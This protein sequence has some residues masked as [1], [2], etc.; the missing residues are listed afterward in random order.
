ML[1]RNVFVYFQGPHKQ[2]FC[3]FSTLLS[4]SLHPASFIPLFLRAGIKKILVFDA[5]CISLLFGKAFICLEDRPFFIIW[6]LLFCSLFCNLFCCAVAKP[7]RG[8]ASLV[9]VDISQRK[10]KKPE[11]KRTNCRVEICFL[12]LKCWKITR[13]RDLREDLESAAIG[14]SFVQPTYS[15][16]DANGY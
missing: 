12:R 16:Q 6:V 8:P 2:P 4:S 11:K 10:K 7:L 3:P 13:T 9:P 14:C 15:L 5:A 1:V